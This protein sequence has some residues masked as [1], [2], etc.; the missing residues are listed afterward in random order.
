[1]SK[2]NPGDRVRFIRNDAPFLKG[3]QATVLSYDSDSIV[4]PYT[5]K[6]DDGIE[7]ICAEASLELLSPATQSCPFS[8]GD[9]VTSISHRPADADTRPKWVSEMDR[10]IGK[11]GI[12]ISI[13]LAD[14]ITV[15]FSD[16]ELWQY[17]SS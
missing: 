4:Y 11:I 12:I 6:R 16:G 3:D 9:R 5:V 7:N 13:R 2:F 15:K 10:Y 17:K 14:I 8:V 1:M